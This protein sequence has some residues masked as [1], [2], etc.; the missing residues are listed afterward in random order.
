MN[1]TRRLEKIVLVLDQLNTYGIAS[2]YAACPS[3]EARRLAGRLEIHHPPKH[4]S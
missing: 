4:G 2:L 1:S 3:P